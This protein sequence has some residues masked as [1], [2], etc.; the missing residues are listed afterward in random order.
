MSQHD[1]LF[2]EALARLADDEISALARAGVATHVVMGNMSLERVVARAWP[3]GQLGHVPS[4]GLVCLRELAIDLCEAEIQNIQLHGLPKL[5]PKPRSLVPPSVALTNARRPLKLPSNT[6]PITVCQATVREMGAP[7]ESAAKRA[8][9]DAAL[10]S[11]WTRLLELGIE[12]SIWSPALQ[13]DDFRECSRVTLFEEWSK[14]S[15]LPRIAKT[16]EEWIQWTVSHGQPLPWRASDSISVRCFL[17]IYTAC[18]STVP[19]TRLFELRWLERNIGLR[20]CTELERVRA[21]VEPEIAKDPQ[22]ARPLN[23]ADWEQM[24]KLLDSANP[25]VRGLLLFWILVILG[26]MRPRHLQRSAFN[27]DDAI[28]G[29]AFRGKKRVSGKAAA[30]WWSAPDIGVTGIVIRRCLARHLCEARCG[31]DVRPFLLPDFAPSRAD[32]SQAVAFTDV[33]MPLAKVRRLSM[34]ALRSAG[35]P[36]EMLD[37]VDGFYSGRRLLPSCAH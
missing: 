18:G 37:T 12:S 2:T 1:L 34:L 8:R 6:P 28:I 35:L 26:V 5:P 20:A 14:V 30:L 25:Y 36:Q 31:T 7:V 29:R 33:P 23:I 22:Q 4:R 21:A 15:N 19:K 27:L 10:I 3:Q 24:E 17:K 9:L 16:L 32:Y 11:I 13:N